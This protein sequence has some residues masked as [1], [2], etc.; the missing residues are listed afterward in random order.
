MKEAK[1]ALETSSLGRNPRFN[2]SQLIQSVVMTSTT[3][4]VRVN[5]TV[6]QGKKVV[7]REYDGN[8]DTAFYFIYF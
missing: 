3:T 4:E 7:Q 8:E 1:N 6:L 5:S 2:L